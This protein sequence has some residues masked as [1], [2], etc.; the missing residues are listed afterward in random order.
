MLKVSDV[1]FLRRT[2]TV[3]RQVHGYGATVEIRA[4]RYGSARVVY[5]PTVLTKMLSEQVACIRARRGPR[6]VTVRRCKRPVP[7]GTVGPMWRKPRDKAGCE[8]MHLHH[9]RHFYA[10][11]HSRRLPRRH[12]ATHWG[13]I[14][15]P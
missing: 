9:L 1:E 3:A 8:R 6:P 10:R 7:A 4:P 14:P 2:I 12:R 15:R 11:P 5:V 13:I